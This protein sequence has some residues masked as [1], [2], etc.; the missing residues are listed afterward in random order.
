MPRYDVAAFSD[1]VKLSFA[2]TI[3]NSWVSS[4]PTPSPTILATRKNAIVVIFDQISWW[5]CGGEKSL[6]WPAT[7]D[8]EG[9]GEHLRGGGGPQ[10]NLSNY[11]A[12]FPSQRIIALISFEE[13]ATTM[14]LFKKKVQF[15]FV[16]LFLK[17]KTKNISYYHQT[18]TPFDKC[19]CSC[20]HFEPN[21][22]WS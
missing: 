17:F 8:K 7:W 16:W 4:S 1:K 18:Y 5:Y 10:P 19:A 20:Y 14:S 6:L 15:Q 21:L 13:K 3:C 11:S 12:W 2:E 9:E 22:F